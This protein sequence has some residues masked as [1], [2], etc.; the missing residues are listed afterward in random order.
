MPNHVHAVVSPQLGCTLSQVLQSWKGFTAREANR[1]LDKSGPFWERESFDHMIRSLHSLERFIDY[2]R[3]NPVSA[4]LCAR[5]EE[6]PYS[7]AFG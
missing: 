5:P 7:S 3:M 1:L 2:T 4:G 6:W